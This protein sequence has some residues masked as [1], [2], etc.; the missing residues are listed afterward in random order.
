MTE[1]APLLGRCKQCDYALFATRDQVQSAD[2][3]KEVR[4]GM[5]PFRVGNEGNFARCP[6]GHKFFALKTVK[7]TYSADHKCDSR[8]LNAKGHSC[9]CSCGGANHGRGYAVTVT[10]AA[11][12]PAEPMAT[13]KQLG[14]LRVLLNERVIPSRPA[15]VL[16][17]PDVPGELRREMA[18]SKLDNKL[19]TK[20]QASKTIEWLLTLPKKEN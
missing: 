7:G 12:V 14:F 18:L 17:V 1:H 13:D 5:G 8:C 11:D 19:F 20:R 4:A 9:T 3:F 10:S 6:Q 15:D 2:S 16:G